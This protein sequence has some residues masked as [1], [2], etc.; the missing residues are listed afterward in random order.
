MDKISAS[1]R[2]LLLISLATGVILSGFGSV[3]AAPVYSLDEVV[4]TAT[5]TPN[6]LYRSAASVSVITQQEIEA[7]HYQTLS[8]ALQHVSGIDSTVFAEGTSFEVSGESSLTIRGT[9]SVLVAVDGVVQKTGNG[10]KSYLMHM[11]MDNLERIEVLKGS[12]STLY[13]A[14]AIGGVVNIVTK[15]GIDQ[16]PQGSVT[17]AAGENDYKNYHFNHQ[18]SEGK[19]FWSL[20]YDKTKKGNYT[21]G[22]GVRNHRNVDADAANIN[23]GIHVNATVDVSLLYQDIRQN[24][25]A[26]YLTPGKGYRNWSHDYRFQNA[27]INVGYHSKD[28]KESNEFSFL[29]GKMYSNRMRSITSVDPNA[30]VVPWEKIDRD[31]YS[32]TNRF[33]KWVSDSNRISAGFEWGRYSVATAAAPNR[34]IRETALYL[35]DEWDVTD[36]MRLTGGLRYV[37]SDSYD[38]QLLNSISLNYAFTDHISA[39]LASNEFYKTPSTNAIFGNASF[40][41]NP[42]I[43]PETGR[44]NE[45]GLKLGIDDSSSLEISVWDRHYDNAIVIKNLPGD[46]PNIYTNTDSVSHIKGAEINLEKRFGDYVHASFSYSR[47][48]AD[49]DA[50][51]PRLPK[52]QYMFSLS[53]IR[54]CYDI[55]LQALN[56]SDFAPNNYFPQGFEDFLPEKNYWVW[57]VSANYKMGQNWKV[58]AK[59]NNLF[60]KGYMSAT[61]YVNGGLIDEPWA[62]Y[63][64][65]GRSFEAGVTYTF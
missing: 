5:T 59:I 42:S 32:I 28:G 43:K 41:P 33:Y 7:N 18:G 47:L 31:N 36:K 27:G 20:S 14:D 6:E 8:E 57:N 29:Y 51:I 24:G 61:Q 3:Y 53:Y 12:A 44:S 35:Q 9:S 22:Y 30:A 16:K 40:Y 48:N 13:G 45:A 46:G 50:Q 25:I 21:D 4:V 52:T 62:Y 58:F 65:Q 19:A 15:K 55:N 49:N 64:A 38:S 56:R 26:R 34:S 17:L 23:V 60:D 11:N 2:S 1:K 54:D 10:Y 63:T 37:N 39:Y